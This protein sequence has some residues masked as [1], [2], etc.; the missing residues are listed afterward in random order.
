MYLQSGRYFQRK[1][2]RRFG[3][4]LSLLPFP[5]ASTE[6]V[7]MPLNKWS[8]RRP[9]PA[10]SIPPFRLLVGPRGHR[11]LTMPTSFIAQGIL[12]S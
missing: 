2:Y 12:A 4:N 6:H 10:V 7:Q 1:H 3:R 5:L 8:R 9:S 11:P